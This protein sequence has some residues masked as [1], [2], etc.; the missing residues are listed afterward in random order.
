MIIP[1]IVSL[2]VSFYFTSINGSRLVSQQ[3]ETYR[4]ILGT[5]KVSIDGLKYLAKLH[6]DD[7]KCN[8][9]CEQYLRNLLGG[10]E[11]EWSLFSNLVESIYGD[12]ISDDPYQ[13]QEIHLALTDNISEMKVI[14]ATMENLLD[15]FVEYTS[16]SNEWTA[17]TTIRAT[18]VNYTYTVPQNWWPVFT[19]VLYEVNMKGL[20]PSQK[21]KYR[22]GGFDSAN[23]TVRTS[24]EYSFKSAPVNNL[25]DQ[26]TVIGGL[27][28]QGT[29]MFL[30]FAVEDKLVAVHEQYGVDM[31]MYAGDLCYAGLSTAL[32]RL[33]ISKEDEFE[34]IWDLW[35][36][37]SEPIAAIMP[38]MIGLGN[39]ERF[40]DWTSVSNRYK[41][42]FEKSGGKGNFRF[43]YDYGNVHW[44]SIDSEDSLEA[45][46]DQ[47]VFLE[48]DLI[49]AVA[50]RGNVPWIVVSLHRP[51][52]SSDESG[53]GDHC[54]GG[55]FPT[56]LEPLFLEYDV[57][58]V[59]AGHIH[60]YERIHPNV[61]GAVSQFPTKYDGV[62]LYRPDNLGPIY[63]V[64]GNAGASQVEHWVQPK[65]EWSALRFAN[66]Y[67]PPNDI[68]REIP[69]FGDITYT[70]TFGFGVL[71]FMNSTHL[72][73][74]AV[75]VTGTL[76]VDQFWIE[77]RVSSL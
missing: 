67:I 74:E 9:A 69:D 24:R 32:P 72:H 52:Y 40:Y 22:V 76:G 39:H 23:N 16:E 6:D 3:V 7:A 10:D 57:D 62:D 2:F 44:I 13:P 54:P 49:K 25:P 65:P 21:Y 53:Y 48:N 29:F 60:A 35:G 30:G 55:R 59:F 43:S 4:R 15:P 77:K 27:A 51:V 42:P 31:V 64:Q 26:K 50:N 71:T 58:L 68:P 46:S 19:G 75:P 70:D 61:N 28:D 38:F 12:E 20:S 1:W 37:Q 66:G 34:H 73:Y 8:A 14:W 47:M 56:A 17:E 33:N 63:V 18:A 36:I 11:L 41:M 5:E 45:G